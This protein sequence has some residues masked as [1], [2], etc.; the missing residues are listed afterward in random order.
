MKATTAWYF[1]GLFHGLVV[2]IVFIFFAYIPVKSELER[3]KERQSERGK[4]ELSHQGG[5]C[6]Y[7]PPG[8]EQKY[9]NYNL[10]SWDAGKTW[11]AIEYDKDCG[12]RWGITILGNAEELYPGLLE[13]IK[14]MDSLTS[15]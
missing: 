12:E 13:H 11:Y 6:L 14:F 9:F 5:G 10:R 1:V 8:W 2:W 3:I 7:K 15:R 4:I